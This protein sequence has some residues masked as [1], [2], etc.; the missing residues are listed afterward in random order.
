M[1]VGYPK[2]APKSV[3]LAEGVRTRNQDAELL[4]GSATQLGGHAGLP[5]GHHSRG[6][7]PW[8][9][10]AC[11]DADDARSDT[12]VLQRKRSVADP[13]AIE[14]DPSAR[15]VGVNHQRSAVARR[16]RGRRARGSYHDRRT[17]RSLSAPCGGAIESGGASKRGTRQWR[18]PRTL[19][20]RVRL[21]QRDWTRLFG[22]FRLID[23]WVPPDRFKIGTE[24]RRGPRLPHTHAVPPR[25]QRERQHQTEC[26]RRQRP[27]CGSPEPRLS[28]ESGRVQ[29]LLFEHSGN[30]SA[31]LQR[32]DISLVENRRP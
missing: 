20:R 13:A 11:L 17:R 32:G 18:G 1:R 16:R 12:N 19:E 25:E 22:V 15:R 5:V 2:S 6:C 10:A 26:K 28:R 24:P 8:F 30:E 7:R 14:R 31:R 21:P 3:G 27:R 23:R 9:V 4:T 29:P